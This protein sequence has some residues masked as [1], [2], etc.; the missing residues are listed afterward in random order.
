MLFTTRQHQ[1]GTP[2]TTPSLR[3][4]ARGVDDGSG[5]QQ[6][7]ATSDDRGNG[8]GTRDCEAKTT[9]A[10]STPPPRA[11]VR[12]VETTG[13]AK[14]GRTQRRKR[15]GA[16]T[17]KTTGATTTKTTGQ[18][19]TDTDSK[20]TDDNDND[21]DGDLGTKTDDEKDDEED[22]HYTTT[23]RA[24][25]RRRGQP[26]QDNDMRQQKRQ[27]HMTRGT[28]RTGEERKSQ[29]TDPAPYDEERKKGP[30]D[31]NVSWAVGK[32]FFISFHFFVTNK[33]FRY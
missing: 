16:T 18:D 13:T 31:V 24:T 22:N 21:D 8:A 4:P 6:N 20:G 17:T 9:T 14:T 26:P 3:A 28:T 23:R 7:R 15:R 12:G 33:L 27:R 10:T 11:A 19:D 5:Q 32:F 25:T 29:A 2:T 30:R 1:D